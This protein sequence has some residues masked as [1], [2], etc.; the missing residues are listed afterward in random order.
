MMFMLCYVMYAVLGR[1]EFCL[2]FNCEDKG[3]FLRIHI[4]EILSKCD[5]Q[6]CWARNLKQII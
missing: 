6:F 5:N 4:E 2:D 1:D 3:I